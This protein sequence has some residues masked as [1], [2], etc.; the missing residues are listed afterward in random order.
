MLLN[1]P[2]R[3]NTDFPMVIDRASSDRGMSSGPLVWGQD[4]GIWAGSSIIEHSSVG[5]KHP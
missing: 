4:P 2:W 3:L 1:R 5:W